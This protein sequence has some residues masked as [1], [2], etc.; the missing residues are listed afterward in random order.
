MNYVSKEIGKN[1]CVIGIVNKDT[2]HTLVHKGATRRGR[3]FFCLISKQMLAS[4]NSCE[5][6]ELSKKSVQF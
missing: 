5:N 6:L 1:F 2:P 3:P 4:S